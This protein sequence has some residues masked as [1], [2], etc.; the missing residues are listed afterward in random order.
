MYILFIRI[1]N[2]FVELSAD[3]IYNIQWCTY[4]NVF[5]EAFFPTT[6]FIRSLC[7][8]DERRSLYPNR[9]SYNAIYLNGNREINLCYCRIEAS[10]LNNFSFRG[11]FMLCIRWDYARLSLYNNSSSSGLFDFCSIFIDFI[12]VLFFIDNRYDFFLSN[13]WGSDVQSF[14]VFFFSSSDDTQIDCIVV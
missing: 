14:T 12:L 13:Y 1:K 6:H 10:L 4:K 9:S 8:S 5:L 2:A 3:I 7:S 11:C